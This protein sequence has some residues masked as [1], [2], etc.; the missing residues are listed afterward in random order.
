MKIFLGSNFNLFYYKVKSSGFSQNLSNDGVNYNVSLYG[1]WK[2]YKKWGVQA[3]GNFNGPRYSVQGRSTSFWYYNLSARREFKNEKGG[4]AIGVDN[5]ASWYMHFRN[6]YTGS[7][8]S[9]SN[10]NKVFFLGAR[11]SFDYRFGKMEFG[12]SKKKKG[13]KND[14]VKDEDPNGGMINGG[15]K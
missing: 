12:N 1:S 13:I 14:D 9:F 11:I 10:D 7:D 15:G 6:D 4:V 2:F 5:F 3:F 8:F